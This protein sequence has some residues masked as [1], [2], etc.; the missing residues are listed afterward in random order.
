M[1][2]RPLI[3]RAPPWI[4]K[5]PKI[6]QI[7]RSVLTLHL[8][9]I[10]WQLQREYKTAQAGRASEHPLMESAN[11]QSGHH[12]YWFP[13][14]HTSLHRIEPAGKLQHQ[15]GAQ[16]FT[17]VEWY[18][19]PNKLSSNEQNPHKPSIV[20]KKS[21]SDALIRHSKFVLCCSS[22]LFLHSVNLFKVSKTD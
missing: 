19:I 15:W 10:E 12:K 20:I 7:S 11:Q 5:S 3:Y 22:N 2:S 9:P 18:K 16:L 21:C 8:C 17:L 13:L 4:G 6:S 14:P 1:W